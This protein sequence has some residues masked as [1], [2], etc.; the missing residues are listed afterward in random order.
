MGRM[1]TARFEHHMSSLGFSKASVRL[2]SKTIFDMIGH[3]LWNYADPQ[4]VGTLHCLRWD[5]TASW[6]GAV[7]DKGSNAPSPP[8]G[9]T[10]QCP[11]CLETAPGV[12]LMPCGHTVCR[13]C[14]AN[15]MG[16][17]CPSCRQHIS[18]ATNGLYMS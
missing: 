18:G 10:V 12:A 6:E 9:T 7:E 14:V 11:I 4:N 17:P 3:D 2:Q 15:V 5:L 13:T 1:L 8:T 16:K